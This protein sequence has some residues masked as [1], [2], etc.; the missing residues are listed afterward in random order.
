MVPVRVC[1]AGKLG[2][3]SPLE[4]RVRYVAWPVVFART[5]Q[6]AW[7]WPRFVLPKKE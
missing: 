4:P 1:A 2:L 5:F 7:I 6:T 3:G